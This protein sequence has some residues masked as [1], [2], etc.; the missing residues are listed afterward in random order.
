MHFCTAC[1]AGSSV[2]SSPGAI[3]FEEEC[4]LAVDPESLPSCQ[5]DGTEGISLINKHISTLGSELVLS[6]WKERDSDVWKHK[7]WSHWCCQVLCVACGTFFSFQFSLSDIFHHIM[8]SWEYHESFYF[9]VVSHK[10]GRGEK[11]MKWDYRREQAYAHCT[12]LTTR[13]HIWVNYQR[14]I[15]KWIT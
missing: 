13:W 3:M 14:N 2:R 4:H 7:L 6:S 1:L 11:E 9:F 8:S 12:E 15:L 10:R 5:S